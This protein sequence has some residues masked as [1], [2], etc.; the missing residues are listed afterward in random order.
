MHYTIQIIK[1]IRSFA[2]FCTFLLNNSVK[3]FAISNDKC[4]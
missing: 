4:Y 2:K 1:C 3:I